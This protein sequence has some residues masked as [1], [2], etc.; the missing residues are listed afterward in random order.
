MRETKPTGSANEIVRDCQ[1]PPLRIGIASYLP[2][3]LLEVW[4]TERSGSK[5]GLFNAAFPRWSSWVAAYLELRS[6]NCLIASLQ[7]SLRSP[8]SARQNLRWA[9]LRLSL[10]KIASNQLGN[11]RRSS[12]AT[13]PQPSLAPG[14]GRA[15]I[16]QPLRDGTLGRRTL[17][18]VEGTERLVGTAVAQ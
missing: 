17:M 18:R 11:P 1:L 5:V 15:W 10:Q 14:L 2:T 8:L 13:L 6:S 4:L 7:L 12:H 9:P 3:K 16:D